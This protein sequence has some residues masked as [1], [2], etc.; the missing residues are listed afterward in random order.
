MYS[1]HAKT[2][3][4]EESS[5][6]EKGRLISVTKRALDIGV[7]NAISGNNIGMISNAIEK[8]VLE[9][10]YDV[11]REYV[12][13]GIG[14]QLHEP[15]SVPNFGDKEDG[16]LLR[17]GMVIAIEPMVTEGSW[18]TKTLDDKWTVVTE[19]GKLSAHFEHTVAI[20]ENGPKILTKT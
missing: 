20:T 6:S 17:V 9:Q 5:N 7:E 4:I 15:P 2:Y 14:E 11:V 1:D 10:G 16:A 18:K 12:G 13:H 3:L 19:D 8:Y